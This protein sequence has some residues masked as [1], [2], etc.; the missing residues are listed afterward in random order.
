VLIADI[1]AGAAG[2]F[3]LG[4]VILY[5]TRPPDTE[6]PITA[7]PVRGGAAIVFGGHF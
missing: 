3:A 5:L 4:T 6:T 1:T 7:V 2:V